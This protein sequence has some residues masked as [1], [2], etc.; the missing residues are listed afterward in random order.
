MMLMLSL[1]VSG[2]II[3]DHN[4]DELRQLTKEDLPKRSSFVQ[5]YAML[6]TEDEQIN[7]ACERFGQD[8]IQAIRDYSEV[9]SHIVSLI[10][11]CKKNKRKVLPKIF[12]IEAQD[13]FGYTALML[14]AS[15]EDVDIV[16]ALCDEGAN[17]EARDKSGNTP[18]IRA[19]Y[20]GKT[21]TVRALSAAGAN[22]E[23]KN[24][25]GKTALFYAKERNHTEIIKILEAAGAQK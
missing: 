18:L 22:I 13:V 25:Y 3:A 2:F 23:V 4:Q 14:A 21:D 15:F 20:C 17:I 9:D 1:F 24:K 11:S 12:N 19:T 10:R 16:R 5:R 7:D 6:R 8:L